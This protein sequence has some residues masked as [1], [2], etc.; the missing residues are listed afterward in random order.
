MG[1]LT[2]LK[3][4]L[5]QIVRLALAE[6]AEDVHLFAA[7]WSGSTGALSRSWL[8]RWRCFFVPARIGRVRCCADELAFAAGRG[9]IK[10]APPRGAAPAPRGWSSAFSGILS[11]LINEIFCAAVPL[12]EIL[13]WDCGY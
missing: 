4:D 1:E 13:S 7:G 5:A 2:G 8:S 12:N 9:A 3:A 11:A 10:A 6:Q